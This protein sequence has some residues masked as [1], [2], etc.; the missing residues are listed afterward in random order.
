[1]RKSL[2]EEFTSIHILTFEGTSA[3]LVS[4]PEGKVARSS[5][6]APGPPSRSLFWSRIPHAHRPATLP[7]A[8]IGDYLSR[9]EKLAVFARVV[10]VVSSTTI[11]TPNEH[12]DWLII[13]SD[14][15]DGSCHS[16][17]S[18]P[19]LGSS[20]HSPGLKTNRDAW[21][22]QLRTRECRS[23]SIDTLHRGGTA[24]HRSRSRA[25]PRRQ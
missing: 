17:G 11:L 8:D 1:M 22:N 20:S 4:S 19:P 24:R 3:Q 2:A 18:A 9:E 6:G 25:R 7:Y 23:T 16:A 21:V 13:R 14:D 15:F 12:G 10:C 5:A